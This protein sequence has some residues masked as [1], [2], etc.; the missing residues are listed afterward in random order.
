MPSWDPA[1]YLRFADARARPFA[2]LL[3]RIDA[4]DPRSVVD[5]GCGPGTLT[6]EL[7]RRWPAAV[8]TGVDS[9]PEMI[10]RARAEAAGDRPVFVLGDLREVVLP[11]DLD[12]L[13]T[14]A[15]LQWV[16]DHLS[17]LDTWLDA[18][19]DGGW[20]ALQVPG[21][22]GAPEHRAIIDL[23]GEPRYAG[24]AAAALERPLGAEPGEYL[25]AL[26]R[27]GVSVDVWETTYLHVLPGAD[28][29]L[30]W[31]R[32]TGARPVL[33]ALTAVDPGLAAAFTEDLRARLR[34]TH[35]GGPGGTVLPFRRVFAVAHR[36]RGPAAASP[37]SSTSDSR[38]EPP[39]RTPGVPWERLHHVQLSCPPGGEDEA[40]AFWEGAMGFTRVAKPESLVPKGGAWFRADPARDNRGAQPVLDVHVGVEDPF[41]RSDRRAHPAL[42]I[43]DEAALDALAARLADRGHDLEHDDL[44]P[45]YRRFYTHD[46]H[47]N[48]IEILCPTPDGA[49]G[50]GA[51]AMRH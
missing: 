5:L 39:A 13:V 50:E 35:P 16:P 51:G 36:G 29:V 18:L 1:Q 37:P 21:N 25:Q 38:R 27:P 33:D 20:L 4:T 22:A 6:A 32:G 41:L 8:V 48:R 43:A 47:G 24:A 31:L 44:L 12:V 45:G 30:E 3:H 42:L 17:L 10:R 9:S 28:P 46:P 7:A 2:D 19:A 15:T 40:A 23:A 11:P 34:R 26:S 14:N 49:A